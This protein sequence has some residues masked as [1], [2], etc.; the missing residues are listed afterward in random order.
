VRRARHAV[1]PRHF[2]N[3]RRPVKH[4]EACGSVQRAVGLNNTVS[5]N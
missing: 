3:S 1:Q 5:L 2:R 4:K